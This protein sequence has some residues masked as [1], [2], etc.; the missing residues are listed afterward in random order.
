MVHDDDTVHITGHIFHAVGN[1][2]YRNPPLSLEKSDLVKDLIPSFGVQSRSRF[3]Q[4]QHLRIHGKNSGDRHPAL[5]SAGQIKR[6][7]LLIFL[8]HPHHTQRFS[9]LLLCFL[10]RTAQILRTKTHIRKHIDLKQL[11]LRILEYKPDLAPQVLHGEI[12]S[13]DIPSIKIDPSAGRFHKPVQMLDQRGLAG[14]CVSDQPHKLSVR[15]LQID[16]LQRMN[17]IGCTF[18]IYI[19]YI[20]DFN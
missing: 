3:I 1:K 14:S 13:I 12:L 5:L 7:T 4:N 2:D 18:C 10:L 6:G 19:I 16:V 15:N 8:S 9:R 17:L 11:M 20:F